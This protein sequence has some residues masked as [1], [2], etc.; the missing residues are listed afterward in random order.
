MNELPG[1]DFASSNGYEL[2]HYSGNGNSASYIKNE[3]H[4]TCYIDG[5]AELEKIL[6]MVSCKIARFSIPNKN[7]KIFENQL[8]CLVQLESLH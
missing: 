1:K 4:L 3:L 7:F 2:H 5:T 8:Y 6:G